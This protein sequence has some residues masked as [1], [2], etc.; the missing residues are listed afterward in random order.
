MQKKKNQL[1]SFKI[2]KKLLTTLHRDIKSYRKLVFEF[3]LG[4]VFVNTHIVYPVVTQWTV[5]LIKFKEVLQKIL[6]EKEV[7]ET[8]KIYKKNVSSIM[9]W[10]I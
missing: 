10:K 2:R 3:L 7:S 6:N 4:A 5:S 1:Q 8:E 9:I